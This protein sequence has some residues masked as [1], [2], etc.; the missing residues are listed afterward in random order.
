MSNKYE[1][2]PCKRFGHTTRFKKSRACVA[3]AQASAKKYR[4]THPY[5]Y[6][7]EVQKKW[8]QAHLQ[9]AAEY[10]AKYRRD[11]PEYT[12]RAQAISAKINKERY[13]DP[14]YREY[15]LIMGK[16]YHYTKM[17]NIE[18]LI[19]LAETLRVHRIKQDE[20]RRQEKTKTD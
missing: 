5:K 1:G 17:Q 3:C 2:K 13:K 10:Q 8:R 18:K 12:K 19:E 7:P 9:E 4:D 15:G 14:L 20:Q 6:D 16:I 11:N